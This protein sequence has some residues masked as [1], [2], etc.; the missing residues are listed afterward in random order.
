MGFSM[1][2]TYTPDNF[3]TNDELLEISELLAKYKTVMAV[4][5]RGEG[6]SLLRSVNE[7]IT[8]AE[9]P[10]FQLKSVILKPQ[11]KTTGTAIFTGLWSL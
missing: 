1:G 9:K 5:M 11:V 4:H 3:Y 10:E 2:L 7:M 6:D 8:I